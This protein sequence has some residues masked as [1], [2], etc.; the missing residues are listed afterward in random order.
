MRLI[1]QEEFD[2]LNGL[3]DGQPARFKIDPIVFPETTTNDPFTKILREMADLHDHKS[4]DYGSGE[5]PY[6]NLRASIGFGI[7]PWM[8][9]LVRAGDKMFR[10]QSFIKNRS[11]KNEGVEDSLLDLATYAV[12]AL[13][14]YREGKLP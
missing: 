10:L 13:V 3:I 12:I 5:D 11:L 14:L 6:A 1:S 7:D 8:G 9:A 4:A 2:R